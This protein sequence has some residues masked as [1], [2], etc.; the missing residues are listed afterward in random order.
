MLAP[1]HIVLRKSTGTWR[2]DRPSLHC[3]QAVYA[4]QRVAERAWIMCNESCVT[5]AGG[6]WEVEALDGRRS[7]SRLPCVTWAVANNQ[8]FCPAAAQIRVI[9]RKQEVPHDGA[10]CDLLWSDPE[11]IEGWGLSPQRRRVICSAAMS[12]PTSIRCGGKGRSRSAGCSMQL[13]SPVCASNAGPAQHGQ[14]GS[15]VHD[16]GGLLLACIFGA[17]IRAVLHGCMAAWLHGCMAPA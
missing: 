9:D 15:H 5:E 1:L 2:H 7:G 4:C 13:R 6:T 10:M 11:D 8:Q 14:T 16:N 12:A 3:C 17:R